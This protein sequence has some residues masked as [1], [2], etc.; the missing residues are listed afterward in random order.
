MKTGPVPNLVLG[1]LCFIIHKNGTTPS[2]TDLSAEN[3]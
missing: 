3:F 1:A 2:P